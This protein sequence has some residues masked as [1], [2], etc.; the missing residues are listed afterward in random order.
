[1]FEA[2]VRESGIET[3]HRMA[4]TIAC[5]DAAER[6]FRSWD[7]TELFYR[8][9]PGRS[10][11]ALLLFHRGHE[12][13]GRLTELVR[14]LDLAD[15]HCFALDARGH[16]RSPGVRGYA[17]DLADLVRDAE[18]FARHVAGE[19][20]IAAEDTVVL[21]HSVG[22]V[23]AAAWVHDYAPPIRAMVLATPAFRVKLYIPGAVPALRLKNALFGRGFV[24][25]YV[26]AGMLTHDP[27]QAAAY[28]ADPLVFRQIADNILL[29][30][31]DTSTRLLDDAGAVHAPAL[32]LAAGSDWIVH[33]K[34]Q[35]RFFDGL[36]SVRKEWELYPGFGHALFHERDRLL[37]I[38]RARDF[39][40]RAFDW[41]PTP[42]DAV[43]Y[44]QAEYDR[45]AHPPPTPSL[46]RACF[47]V[48][49]A[50]LSTVGRLS[51]GVRLG[52][53]TGFDSGLSL[54]YVYANRPRGLTTLGRQIDRIYLGSVGW[55]G[56]RQRKIHLEAMLEDA[57][58]RVHAE[59]RPAVVLDIACG[60][61]R[62]VLETIRRIEGAP[63]TVLLRDWTEAN[64]VAAR[65]LAAELGLRDVHAVRADAFDRDALA[66]VVPQPT[67]AI[68]SG[69]Y[70]L[71]P[72]NG[73]VRASLAGLADAM[74]DG[75]RL[76]YTGQPWHPQIEFI[77]R[78]LINR[79]GKPWIMRRRTQAE[80]DALVREAGFEKISQRV[81][82]W[83]IF[84]VSMA[85]RRR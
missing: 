50:A 55:R 16:G 46:R 14:D 3:K 1:M 61:G 31:F 66:A 18:C 7:G 39:I 69:L 68:V 53:E 36:S 29:D 26:K 30:L 27:A 51:D 67:V 84:T 13:S 65:A 59:G 77:A 8:H 43:R 22:A 81:D 11:R 72:D 33:V 75:G 41:P 20:G 78:V 44:T 62:Y 32:I 37:P 23:V 60:A 15:F 83:G 34:A 48:A 47:A 58:W 17:D 80:L 9:W 71:F 57:L 52:W 24:Q 74:P 73:P 54:D 85:R 2:T 28:A 76:L 42:V 4:A 45:L 25:S 70:E 79:E 12:H 49:R 64:L 6:T 63:V 35:R 21:A 82:R 40:V 19:S 5:V 10:P 38:A 56:I